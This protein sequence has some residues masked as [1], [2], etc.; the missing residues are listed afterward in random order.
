MS[1]T[2]P[3]YSAELLAKFGLHVWKINLKTFQFDYVSKGLP[4]LYGL[5]KNHLMANPNLWLESVLPE[6]RDR[7][8]TA[9]QKLL[10]QVGDSDL[11]YRI[12]KPLG[13]I[14]WIRD[15]KRSYAD[16]SG[17][18]AYIEGIVEDITQRK[19][20]DERLA[21]SEKRYRLYFE[22]N[23]KPMWVYDCQTLQFLEVNRAA[24]LQYGYSKGEFKSMKIT[25]IRPL[26]EVPRLLEAVGK[27][28][29]G[30]H[31]S[32]TWT[33]QNKKGDSFKVEIAGYVFT[34]GM[35]K[36]ELVVVNDITNVVHFA[37]RLE[38][39]AHYTSHEVRKPLANI[40]AL[41]A[42]MKI[43]QDPKQKEHLCDTLA[44]CARELDLVLKQAADSIREKSTE[45]SLF[46]SMFNKHPH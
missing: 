40:L 27:L 12:Q 19:I 24:E 29:S 25:D 44:A 18:I 37:A 15:L 38:R 4:Q 10:E 30:M 3:D 26:D 6:D 43:E 35:Q 41:V 21:I 11:I 13:N 5:T 45:N 20:M 9:S 28:R 14:I 36:K 7:V 17:E 8:L 2:L 1:R 33:H 34:D 16:E 23:P 42:L 39:Y 22:N 31:H 46:E 32:R